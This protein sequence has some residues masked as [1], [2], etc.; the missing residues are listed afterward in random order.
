MN[1]EVNGIAFSKEELSTIALK[2]LSVGI[3]SH[4]HLF[5]IPAKS[6][7]AF[8]I[9]RAGDYIDQEFVDNYTQKG[10]TSFYALEIATSSEISEYKTLFASLNSAYNEKERKIV[11]QRIMKKFG[12]D[13]WTESKSSY[14]SFVLP[15]FENF[16]NLP[17]SVVEKYQ[18]TSLTLYS[19]AMISASLSVM[20]CFVHKI[21]DPNF[22]KD[23]YNLIFVLDYGLLEGDK[24]T[25]SLVVACEAERNIPGT[26]ISK[27][28]TMN[29]PTEEID[30]FTQHPSQSAKYIETL[31]DNFAY[32]E[33]IDVVQYHHEK[34]DGS[35]FPSGVSYSGIG[36]FET[37]QMFCD[38]LVP[39]QEHVYKKGDGANIIKAEFLKV[40]NNEDMSSLPINKILIKWESCM[41]W[42]IKSQKAQVEEKVA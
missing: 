14:L 24:F 10:I 7:N 23:L 17:E 18:N 4:A 25:Y 37:F 31:K 34:G 13:Y 20:T 26:G 40:K 21:V 2:D 1:F 9:L 39:F 22:I 28:Q 3:I 38:Y 36:D 41:D 5:Y 27:L 11:A 15:C 8:M 19:R 35:G 29:R 6:K 16:Y 42:T 12:N 30:L 32:P 33:I